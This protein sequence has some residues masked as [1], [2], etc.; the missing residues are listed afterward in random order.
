MCPRRQYLKY[1]D[2]SD[3]VLRNSRKTKVSRFIVFI[4]LSEADVFKVDSDR[5][6]GF[7]SLL[8]S[9]V[10]ITTMLVKEIKDIEFLDWLKD[11]G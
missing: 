9:F 3:M 6:R 1:V 2:A 11:T 5:L 10:L 7:A 8:L 4:I